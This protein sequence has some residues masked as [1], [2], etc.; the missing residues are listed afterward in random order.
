[1]SADLGDRLKSTRKRRGLS[2]RELANNSGVSLSLIRKLEQGD[3]AGVRLETLR[4]LAIALRTRTSTLQAGRADA[5]YADAETSDVWEPVRRALAGLDAND[6]ID[7]QPTNAGVHAAYEALMPMIDE[8][9]YGETS[10]VLP[11]LLCDAD[12]L[13]DHEGRAIRAR[14]LSMTGWMLTQ[15]RQFDIAAMTLD[16]AI[17]AAPE[18]GIAVGAVNVLVWSA[19]RQG[20]LDIARELAVKWADDIEPRFSRATVSQL[21]LWGRLWLYV[22]NVGVRDNSPGETEDALSL[23]RAAADRIGHEVLYDPNPN[24][25]FGPVTVAQIT[26]ECAVIAEQPSKTLAIAESLPTTVLSPT[27]AGRL[28]HRLDVAN[29]HTQLRQHG[30]ATHTLQQLRTAAPEWLAQQRYARDILGTIVHQR[31]TL[32]DEMRELA[33]LVRLEY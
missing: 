8:H 33:E 10:A 19:L 4:K 11:A 7:E 31:R 28:R 15:N 6:T 27:A 23:A 25:L 3:R 5:E 2:Q 1:M 30:E 14:L 12:A 21:A 9:R 24:R 20:R 22:A 26:G 13:T 32:T 17:D 18:R 16:Q 29:A